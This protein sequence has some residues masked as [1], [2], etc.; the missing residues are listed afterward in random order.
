MSGPG[1]IGRERS[2]GAAQAFKDL[3]PLRNKA[4]KI[5]R[6]YTVEAEN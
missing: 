1:Q 3:D 6:Q 4:I 5:V 2:Y